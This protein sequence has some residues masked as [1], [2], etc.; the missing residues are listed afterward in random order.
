MSAQ[1][2]AFSTQFCLTLVQQSLTH[3]RG[4][5]LIRGEGGLLEDLR[6][7]YAQVVE[8][9]RRR[10]CGAVQLRSSPAVAGGETAASRR[11]G[12]FNT[13]Q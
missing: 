8:E 13:I 2:R 12:V 6:S 1:W 3:S 7:K 5:G 11:E 4:G 9:C 10:C